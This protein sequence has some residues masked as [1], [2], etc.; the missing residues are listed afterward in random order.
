[1]KDVVMFEW[2]VFVEG[3]NEE[4]SIFSVM[5]VEILICFD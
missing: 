1:M 2:N 3:G 5:V 4:V